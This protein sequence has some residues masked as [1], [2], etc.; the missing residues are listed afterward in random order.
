MSA[1]N[2]GSVVE[3]DGDGDESERETEV[4][5][6]LQVEDDDG[7]RRRDE[8][9]ARDEKQPRDVARVLHHRRHD[10]TNHRL[11]STNQPQIE[12]SNFTNFFFIFKI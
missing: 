9:R 8:H 4:D 5:V 3:E 7:Q 6:E 11:T 12:N 1:A 2:L 10:Q